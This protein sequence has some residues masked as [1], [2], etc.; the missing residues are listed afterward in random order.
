[1]NYPTESSWG[2][3]ERENTMTP[4]CI[5]WGRTVT[6][7]WQPKVTGVSCKVRFTYSPIPSFKCQC[8]RK[9]VPGLPGLETPGMYFF[10]LN[11]DSQHGW[12][13]PSS[14]ASKKFQE[15]HRVGLPGEDLADTNITPWSLRTIT[16]GMVDFECDFANSHY[17]QRKWAIAFKQDYFSDFSNW[18]NLA[19]FWELSKLGLFQ[20]SEPLWRLGCVPGTAFPTN[21]KAFI[22]SP[23]A[24]PITRFRRFKSW[25]SPVPF[26]VLVFRT[27]LF[28]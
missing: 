25:P 6:F 26:F 2:Q 4:F 7:C 10:F 11:A 13:L 9:M 17:G 27:W 14:P 5:R 8:L 15:D 1:M 22:F 3:F 12:I 18:L 21:L 23:L 24:V 28:L 19:V 20:A 16:L